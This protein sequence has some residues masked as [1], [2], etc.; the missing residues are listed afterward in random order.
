MR[1]GI[2]AKKGYYLKTVR[3]SPKKTALRNSQPTKESKLRLPLEEMPNKNTGRLTQSLEKRSPGITGEG[4]AAHA[5]RCRLPMS[6]GQTDVE[7]KSPGSSNNF[8]CEDSLPSESEVAGA[9][10]T[11]RMFLRK[12]RGRKP[13]VIG[14]LDEIESYVKRRIV[15]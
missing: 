7:N 4:A 1:H 15:E 5:R 13:T 11:L 12:V 2:T 3:N 14:R 8:K 6:R 9:L 10:S